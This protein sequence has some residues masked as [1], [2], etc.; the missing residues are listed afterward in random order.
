L[1]IHFPEPI[2]G[3]ELM[4]LGVNLAAN[5]QCANMLSEAD[6]L[7][8]LIQRAFKYGDILLF[9]MIRNISQFSDSQDTIDNFKVTSGDCN[10]SEGLCY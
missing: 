5:K 2:V 9:K 7:D 1:I 8:N 6:Q 3:R 4:A 10:D